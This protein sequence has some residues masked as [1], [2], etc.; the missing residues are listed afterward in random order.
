MSC[1]EECISLDRL[2]LALKAISQVV[3]PDPDR[4]ADSTGLSAD[5]EPKAKGVEQ[6]FKACGE[7]ANHMPASATEVQLALILQP[8]PRFFCPKM[9]ADPEHTIVAIAA[10]ISAHLKN[11]PAKI[12]Y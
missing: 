3:Y 11:V 8:S 9:I 5:N 10:P 7:A 4:E 1:A 6:A 12:T 2:C